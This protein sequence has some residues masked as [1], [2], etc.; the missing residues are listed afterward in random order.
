MKPQART[1]LLRKRG[2]Q[3]REGGPRTETW[4]PHVLGAQPRRHPQMDTGEEQPEREEESQKTVLRLQ[5][6]GLDSAVS[7]RKPKSVADSRPGFRFLPCER[8]VEGG[9]PPPSE[10]Q[11]S[12]SLAPLLLALMSHSRSLRG[13]KM[14]AAGL[15]ITFTSWQQEG[16]SKSLLAETAQILSRSFPGR[17]LPLSP[18][19]HASPASPRCRGG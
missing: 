13:H 5:S 16:R 9:G 3:K 6:P 8:G 2:I 10:T 4:G 14:A 12:L 18:T 11:A 7:D 15:A 19:A 1:R 17:P